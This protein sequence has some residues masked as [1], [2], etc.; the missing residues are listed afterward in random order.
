MRYCLVL[1]LLVLGVWTSGA[2]G[3]DYTAEPIQE[4]PP[5]GEVSE[6]IGKLLAPTGVRISRGTRKICDIWVCH[7]WSLKSFDLGTNL[8]YPFQPGQLLGVVVFH[9]KSRDFR[10]QEIEK[11]V[12]TMRY[13]Q[14]PEDGNHVG[15]SPTRDFVLLIQGS[16]D[17]SAAPLD[18]K[19]LTKVSA[20]A[21]GTKHPCLLSLQKPEP[22]GEGGA[23]IRS[24]EEFEWWIVRL[25]GKGKVE[26]QEKNLALELVVIGHVRE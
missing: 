17:K 4:A 14:Q 25:P 24:Q 1:S 11:G 13:G 2:L 8:L 10:E 21:A 18:Y 7:E 22:G 26:A 23:S 15:T 3:Q 5:T 20:E 9:R 16:K 19:A 6:E 12:Y